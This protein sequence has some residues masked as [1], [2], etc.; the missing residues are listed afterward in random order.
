MSLSKTD[1]SLLVSRIPRPCQSSGVLS[2]RCKI[3]VW[4]SLLLGCLLLFGRAHPPH[5]HKK[6][7]QLLRLA[8]PLQLF[9]T[10]FFSPYFSFHVCVSYKFRLSSQNICTFGQVMQPAG[11]MPANLL[12]AEGEVGERGKQSWHGFYE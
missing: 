4:L 1:S 5:R 6:H 9:S 12:A 10:T 3:G 7:H 2:L 11:H 8:E